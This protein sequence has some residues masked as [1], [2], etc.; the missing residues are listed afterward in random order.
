M[1]FLHSA[2]LGI[3]VALGAAD[4]HAQSVISRQID[5]EPVETTVTQTPSGTV[6]TRRPLSATAPIVESVETT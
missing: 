4:A 5:N 2:T 6:V 3:A 1:R